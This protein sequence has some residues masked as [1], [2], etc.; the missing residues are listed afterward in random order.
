[1][2]NRILLISRFVFG[3]VFLYLN[4]TAVSAAEVADTIPDPD[5]TE[6]DD[7]VVVQ[8][9][10]LVESDGA[11]LSYNVGEDP[12]AQSSDILAILRKVPGVTV[13]ADDNIKVNG[14]S[15]FKILMNGREDP[16]LKGDLKTALKSMPAGMIRKIEVISEPGAKYEAEGIGGILNIITDKSQS[17][18]GFMT[19]LQA[20]MNAY[21]AGGSLNGRVKIDKVMLDATVNYNNGY[22]WPRK[23]Y[24]RQENE[25]LTDDTNHFET[26]DRTRHSGWDYTGTNV[27]LSWEP[28]SINLFTF[29]GNYAYNGW[30]GPTRETRRT[31]DL[32][33]RPIRELS[34]G[35]EDYGN[36]NG[37]GLMA[38]YQHTFG[39]E[40]HNLVVSYEFD[41]NKMSYGTDYELLQSTGGNGESPFSSTK[42]R[43]YDNSHIVQVDYSNPFNG[44][45]LLEAGAKFNLNDNR[46]RTGTF[47]GNDK[48]NAVVNP[49]DEVDVTQF[50]DIYAAYAS[51]VL[52][53]EKWNVKGG[54][55]FEHTSMGLRYKA[56]DFS[57]F[58]TI[59]NDLV[60][61]LAASYNF[62]TASTLRLAYQMRISRPG[63]GYLNPYV[64]NLTPG[65]ISYGNPNL[66]SQRGHN[67]SL[68]Y[69]NYEGRFSGGAKVNYR[70]ESNG[71]N[72]VIFVR[73]GI[74]NS[75]YAN[76]GTTREFSADLNF[77]WNIF[78]D[79]RWSVY[80]S[81]TYEDLRA[82]S[83]L[84]DAVNHG[85]QY[86]V[87]SN[88][89][90]TLPG[91]VR[92]SA[93]GGYWTPWIDLQSKGS[94]GYYYGI[95]ASRAFLKDDALNVSVNA[96]NLFPTGRRYHYR[97]SDSMVRLYQESYSK[98]WN[99]T[100]SVSWK[101]G[102]LK[103][104]VR[105]TSARIEKEGGPDAGSGAKGNK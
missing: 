94:P 100:L 42:S 50:K 91:K 84:L 87:S 38:S 1:M 44:M 10:K 78:S 79:F 45:H 20:W 46:V 26:S 14:S 16:M 47:L 69:T 25:I 22:V 7:F 71:I 90:Y 68:G 51:Y 30:G 52:T 70:Y 35:Y 58:T 4:A 67:L 49:D 95:G 75:T 15:S 27:N 99:L 17:L 48:G 21:N 97:Q 63:L 2:K 36:F 43:S 73:D 64:N 60:P 6:L 101:F 83:E 104:T 89:G 9:K 80:F 65:W 82:H 62:R 11:K 55:R 85:W 54:L 59:L 66:K 61:N 98:Q 8:R 74:I 81:A 3:I 102:G 72:D 53:L 76:I 86:S 28:D 93:Y 37:W 19:Q 39:K 31:Y 24:S 32:N 77:D 5:V 40:G 88:I 18:Q 34:R 103:K 57:S 92:L 105:Q 13:D 33:M 41:R 96:G 23:N 12:E 29:S 56:G